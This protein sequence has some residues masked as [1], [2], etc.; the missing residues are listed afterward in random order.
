M[1]SYRYLLALAPTTRKINIVLYNGNWDAV[2][3]Y[4]DTLKNIKKLNL[5]E[6]YT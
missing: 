6:S 2:V 3:P 4:L 5:V 1:D